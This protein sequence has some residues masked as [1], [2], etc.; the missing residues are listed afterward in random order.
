MRALIS[1]VVPALLHPRSLLL[2]RQA[3]SVIVLQVSVVKGPANHRSLAVLL[4][5]GFPVVVGFLLLLMNLLNNLIRPA[6]FIHPFLR[7]GSHSSGER[8]GPIGLL[9]CAGVRF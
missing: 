1:F 8:E 7:E 9:R 5:V 6:M 2:N 3:L 4:G